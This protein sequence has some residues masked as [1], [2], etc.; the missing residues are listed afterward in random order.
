LE[1]KRRLVQFPRRSG[2]AKKIVRTDVAIKMRIMVLIVDDKADRP[3]GSEHSLTF[4][5]DKR[6][7]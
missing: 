1:V 7:V 2:I 5:Q 6:Y 4:I 3:V